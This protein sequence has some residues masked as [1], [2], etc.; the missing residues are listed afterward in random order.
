VEI[1]PVAIQNYSL[2]DFPNEL[3]AKEMHAYAFVL[4][5]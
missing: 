5:E 2:E 3:R 1:I 4:C